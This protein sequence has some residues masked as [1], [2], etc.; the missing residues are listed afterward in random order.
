MIQIKYHCVNSNT[1][2]CAY[3]MIAYIDM[4]MKKNSALTM[5]EVFVNCASNLFLQKREINI[6]IRMVSKLAN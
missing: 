2:R 4:K 1:L 3:L 5:R 6:V